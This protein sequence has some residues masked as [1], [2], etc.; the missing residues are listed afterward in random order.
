MN[1]FEPTKERMRRLDSQLRYL[2]E[3]QRNAAATQTW[4][5]HTSLCAVPVVARVHGIRGAAEVA[6]AA[7]LACGLGVGIGLAA[8]HFFH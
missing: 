4:L 7:V 8:L 5:L 1:N 6:F 2:E 3:K